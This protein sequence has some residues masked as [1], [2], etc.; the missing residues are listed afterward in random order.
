MISLSTQ[1]PINLVQ[2]TDTHLYAKPVGT[3]LKTNTSDT[4]GHVIDMVQAN[5]ANINLLLATGDIAQD[6][7]IEAY[8]NFIDSIS[9]FDA[10]CRWIPGNHDIASV[11][12]Q[13]TSK[14]D[15]NDKLLKINN[16]L[17][18]MLDSS[19][20]GQV[21][22]RLSEA[23]LEFLE[24]TLERAEED[25]AVGHCFICLHHNPVLGNSAWMKDIGLYNEIEFASII[26]RF[27]KVN[28]VMYGH[29]HQE[30]DFVLDDVRYFC[31]PSTCIQFKPNVTNFSLDEL[32]PGYRTLQ[33]HEDG[34]ID[35]KVLRVSVE[36]IEPDFNGPGY[37]AQMQAMTAE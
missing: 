15:I 17:V 29:I 5:E 26:H 16:W 2:L 31:A 1:F 35:S 32:N 37:L 14:P 25:D 3:L 11:M 8:N 9:V 6:A 4:L 20:E 21:H 10:P 33:L 19:I 7:T 36:D 18:I 28:S 30:L 34:S 22:G 13:I 24:A 12:Q 23:E 27:S